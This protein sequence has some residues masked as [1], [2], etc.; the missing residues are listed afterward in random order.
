MD[1]K[2]KS[3]DCGKPNKGNKDKGE[4]LGNERQK[5]KGDGL[6]M[7]TQIAAT[8]IIYGEEAKKIMREAKTTQSEKSKMNAK[9]LT[10]FFS[11]YMQKED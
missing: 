6:K 3:H 7:A 1:N 5:T 4:M 2:D 10:D 11:K 8:P 9:K